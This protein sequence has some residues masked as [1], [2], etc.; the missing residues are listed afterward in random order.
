MGMAFCYSRQAFFKSRED[1]MKKKLAK[2]MK[3]MKGGKNPPQVTRP[4]DNP[5][6]NA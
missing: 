4:K 5:T 2:D 6:Y 1:L 3:D